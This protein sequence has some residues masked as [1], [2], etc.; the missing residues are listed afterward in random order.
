MAYAAQNA[1]EKNVARLFV[2]TTALSDAQ[3]DTVITSGKVPTSGWV[4]LETFDGGVT[5]S[6][7]RTTT[8]LTSQQSGTIDE[9]VDTEVA[10]LSI[11]LRSAG[12]DE[13]I[14]L[15]AV[16]LATT[17]D[18]LSGIP[19]RE[20]RGTLISTRALSFMFYDKATDAN[21]ETNTPNVTGDAQTYVVFKAVPTSAPIVTMN[22]V[23]NSATI[24][25]KCLASTSTGSSRNIWGR[26]GVFTAA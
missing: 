22:N 15:M 20:N 19:L 24:T 1:V 3:C 21:N 10:T 25:Y 18:A 6:I 23:Q 12:L 11:T 5:L 2:K 9:A 8:P 7:D 17:G 13:L 4:Q 16:N 14:Y 26:A